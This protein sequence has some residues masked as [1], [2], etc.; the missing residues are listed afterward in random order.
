MIDRARGDRGPSKEV[1]K[2]NQQQEAEAVIGH[3]PPHA[4]RMVAVE[5]LL[6]D[7]EWLADDVLESLLYLMRERLDEELVSGQPAARTGQDA[8]PEDGT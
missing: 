3:L 4:A 1:G 2:M 7:P 5:I 6:S 8:E